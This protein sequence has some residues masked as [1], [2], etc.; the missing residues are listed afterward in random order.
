M[1]FT[2]NDPHQPSSRISHIP[3]LPD[4]MVNSGQASAEKSDLF[5]WDDK[6][7]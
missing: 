2:F 5:L 7:H 1:L 4:D 3:H 6:S